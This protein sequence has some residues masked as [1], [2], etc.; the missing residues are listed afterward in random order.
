MRAS[1]ILVVLLA[2]LIVLVSGCM[3]SQAPSA[4]NDSDIEEDIRTNGSAV[5]DG[6]H[7]HA[8]EALES[9]VSSAQAFYGPE[10]LVEGD[11]VSVAALEP[12]EPG[13][14]DPFYATYDLSIALQ[15]EPTLVYSF[16]VWVMSFPPGD[17]RREEYPREWG[18]TLLTDV[19]VE[20]IGFGVGP[21]GELPPDSRAS[22]FRYLVELESETA[23]FYPTVHVWGSEA[24]NRRQ[25]SLIE[26]I[27]NAGYASEDCALVSWSQP[28]GVEWTDQL[29]IFDEGQDDWVVLKEWANSVYDSFD[30]TFP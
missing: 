8:T 22:M 2:C 27:E 23:Y 19:D 3:E 11:V 12:A 4:S 30:Y 6:A 15:D 14:E 10:F 16:E 21:L 26:Q 25:R 7:V 1:S 13:A 9:I 28:E 18:P 29:V 24:E 5:E 17:P 20:D